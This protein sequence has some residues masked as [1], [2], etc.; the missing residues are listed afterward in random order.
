MSWLNYI[1]VF[2]SSLHKYDL[3]G[4]FFINGNGFYNYD[5]FLLVL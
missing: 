2:S 4:F 3:H 1:I 5:A